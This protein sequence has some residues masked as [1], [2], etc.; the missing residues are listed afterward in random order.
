MLNALLALLN[1]RDI[2][3]N[4]STSEAPVSIHLS[5]LD[6]VDSGAEESRTNLPSTFADSDCNKGDPSDGA[7]NSKIP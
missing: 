3:R 5:R 2:I 4:K 6:A 7:V 1:S